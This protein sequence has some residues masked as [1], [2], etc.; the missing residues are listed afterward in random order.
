MLTR[1]ALW[2]AAARTRRE[3]SRLSVRLRA[4]IGVADTPVIERQPTGMVH[5]LA[6]NLL[7]LRDPAPLPAVRQTR[8]PSPRPARAPLTGAMAEVGG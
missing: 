2:L 7:V 4:D 3:L 6:P 8:L 1:I 5:A